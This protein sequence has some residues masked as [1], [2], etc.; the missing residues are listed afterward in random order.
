VYEVAPRRA[1][2][3]PDEKEQKYEGDDLQSEQKD[4]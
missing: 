1:D 4:V 3:P 2:H